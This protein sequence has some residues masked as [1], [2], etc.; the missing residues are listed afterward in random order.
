[1]GDTEP[2]ARRWGGPRTMS[3]TNAHSTDTHSATSHSVPP[4]LP[5]GPLVGMVHLR[6]LPGSPSSAMR[7]AEIVKV[8]VAE[9]RLLEEAGFDALIV[10]NMH[11]RP[12]LADAGTADTVATFAIA[13]AAVTAA[14][15]IP[16]GVQVLSGATSAALAI[17]HAAGGSFIR[18]EGFV[19]ASV[20]DEGLLA[21]AC[22]GPLLRERRRI[23]ASSVRI[24]ADIRKKHSSHAITG[25]L[26]GA[27]WARAAEFFGADGIIVTGSETGAAVDMAELASV[28]AATTLPVLVGSGATP[29]GAAALLE[30]ADALIVGSALKRDGL[31]SNEIDPVR[32]D[33][34]VRAVRGVRTP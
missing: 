24:L 27:A 5:H 19:F 21:E 33:A 16:V 12:Y 31:W 10:E 20:A 9:A 1:M 6:A 29:Q 11:D 13:T 17:A 26:D 22:A 34:M 15:R 28:R 7:P 2:R 32:A 30:H 23:G 25:D 4:R 18:A 14:V 3:S 8:A